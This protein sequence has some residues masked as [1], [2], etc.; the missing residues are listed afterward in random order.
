M[1]VVE[2]LVA[3]VASFVVVV[4]VFVRVSVAS[5]SHVERVS[6]VLAEKCLLITMC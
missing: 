5:L 1:F 4:V 3:D 2:Q 6:V